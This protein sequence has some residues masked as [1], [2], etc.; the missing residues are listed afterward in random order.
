MREEEEAIGYLDK[1]LE[2]EDDVEPGT[3]T[4]PRWKSDFLAH[5]KVGMKGNM[6]PPL[7]GVAVAT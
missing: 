1:V 3:F 6:P 7:Q 4:G 5:E 2:D